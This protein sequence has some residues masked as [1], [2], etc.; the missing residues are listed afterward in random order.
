MELDIFQ[1]PYTGLPL[2]WASAKQQTGLSD[3]GGNFFPLRNGYPNFLAGQKITGLN[4]KF[5]QFYDRTGRMAGLF[6][7]FLH[8]FSPVRRQREAWLEGLAIRPGDRVL[9]VSV[10]AGWNIRQLPAEANYHGMDIS[11][12]M[13]DHCIQNAH[14]WG[15]RLQLC[16]ANAEFLPYRDNVFD[17]VFHIGGINFFNDRGRAI[18]EMIRVA[19]PGAP[20]VII[21]HTAKDLK[22]QY[23]KLAFMRHCFRETG[24]DRSRLYAP[25]EF[26]PEE[27]RDVEVKLLDNGSMYRLSFNKPA[28]IPERPF[29]VPNT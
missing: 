8:L 19:K 16:Q 29:Y 17:S 15:V 21:D 14:R 26:V 2:Q 24:L 4:Q 11:A 13:L 25:A 9:E 6:E 27:I 3:A 20:V 5:Q 22:K 12:G 28:S 1:N 10:G 7:R 23:R 18:R